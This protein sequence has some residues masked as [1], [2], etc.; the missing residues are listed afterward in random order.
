[1][2]QKAKDELRKKY[3]SIRGSLS[4]QEVESK[5]EKIVQQLVSSDPFKKA[6][7]VHSYLPITKN[8]EVNTLEFVEHCIAHGKT[9]VIPKVGAD[10][11]MSHHVLNSFEELKTNSWGVAEPIHPNPIS[12]SE[13]DLVIV[14]MVCGDRYRNRIGYGK[15]FYDRFLSQ[16][17]AF[18]IGLLYNCTLTDQ[19]IPVEDF[20]QKPDWLISEKE[21]IR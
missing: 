13:I 16:T 2:G 21:I 9:V 18:K 14:P 10:Q 1:M 6:E 8:R 5:S 12:V 17:D 20:D 15:G 3:L 7:T 4:E 19:K 11:Q